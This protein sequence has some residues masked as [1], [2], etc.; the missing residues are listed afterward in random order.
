MVVTTSPFYWVGCHIHRIARRCE[1]GGSGGRREWGGWGQVWTG[2][3]DGRGGDGGEATG[4]EATGGE[5]TG[6]EATGGEATGGEA[7]GGEATGGEA[8]GG[9][10]GLAGGRGLHRGRSG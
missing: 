6:G 9:E 10:A 5:A 7:T 4:G 1:W 3:G 2:E 8:T